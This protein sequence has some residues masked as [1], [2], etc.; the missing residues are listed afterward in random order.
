MCGIVVKCDYC[1]EYKAILLTL[2]NGY[3]I[4]MCAYCANEMDKYVRAELG[5]EIFHE[6]SRDQQVIK[7]G[8]LEENTLR[9]LLIEIHGKERIIFKVQ[10]EWIIENVNKNVG[11]RIV[12]SLE[13]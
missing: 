1:P 4:Y 5:D 2:L 6:W 12:L 10:K 11:E 9:K 7:F 8:D 3:K 13:E